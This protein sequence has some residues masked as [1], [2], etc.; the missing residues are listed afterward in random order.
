MPGEPVAPAFAVEPYVM[1]EASGLAV[2]WQTR[3]GADVDTPRLQL[4]A[5][6]TPIE[7][8]EPRRQ[9][10]LFHAPLPAD[11]SSSPVTYR[12]P[13]MRVP[14]RVRLP[15]CRDADHVEFAFVSDTQ[16]DVELVHRLSQQIPQSADFVLHG[17]DMV[18]R[19]GSD[20]Q[21]L[22]Y[23]AASRPFAQ[24]VATISTVGNH[25]GYWDETYSRFLSY[26]APESGATWFAFSSGPVDVLVLNS[27]DIEKPELN[28]AQLLW[29]EQTLADLA[30]APDA[31]RRWRIV[32]THHAPLSSSL[33]NAWFVPIGRSHQLRAEY[34]PLFE[35]YDVDLV[36]AG[37]AHV[38]ER[39]RRNG[40]EYVVGGPAGGLMGLTGA[41]NPDSITR[42]KDRTVSHFKAN[43]RTLRMWTR[44]VDGDEID[45][46]ELHRDGPT[47]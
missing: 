34:M 26:F 30:N 43:A 5:D 21:W 47:G 8:V 32:L 22:R 20:D 16:Q 13:G 31:E 24:R 39:S 7:T 17:G 4:L 18:Q 2:V 6:D 15:P 40:I 41:D 37:H 10:N 29:L 11:C 12:V 19:G 42:A 36:L 45:R 28:E 1:R 38:Y 9:G 23:H 14:R 44:N 3:A 33:A 25:E 35:R 27:Q 46:V